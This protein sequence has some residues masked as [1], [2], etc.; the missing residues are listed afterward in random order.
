MEREELHLTAT[1]RRLRTAT[2]KNREIRIWHLVTE[3]GYRMM[4]ESKTPRHT[5]R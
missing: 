3:N 4:D 5:V 2:Q 1:S